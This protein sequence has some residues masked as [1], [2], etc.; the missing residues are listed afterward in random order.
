MPRGHGYLSVLNVVFLVRRLCDDLITRP[1]EFYRLWWVSVCEVEAWIIR[2]PCHVEALRQK[3]N[4]I[5]NIQTA[6]EAE[7]K[8]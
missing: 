3:K 7:G 6:T 8:Q 5:I 4:N 1:E 2:R